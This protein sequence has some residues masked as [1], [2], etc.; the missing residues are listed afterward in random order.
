MELSE[1]NSITKSV[2]SPI[3][4]LYVK[5]A[6]VVTECQ[7]QSINMPNDYLFMCYAEEC[8]KI[9]L[10]PL[11]L[12]YQVSSTCRDIS[13]SSRHSSTSRSQVHLGLDSSYTTILF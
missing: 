6:M 5:Y 2:F 13:N 8:S 10:R 1:T 11:I 4:V 3:H 7:G 9:S 12:I